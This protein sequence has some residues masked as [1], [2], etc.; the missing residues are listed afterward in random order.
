MDFRTELKKRI[1]VCDGAMGTRLYTKG[2]FINR[3]FEE[4]SLS[5]PYLVSEIHREYIEAGA[6]ILESNTFGANRFKLKPYGLVDKLSDIVETGV[7]LAKNEAKSNC[8]VA[9]S[10][11]PLGIPIKLD[12]INKNEVHKAFAEI[13]GILAKSGADLLLLETF[14]DIVELEMAVNAVRSVCDLPVI[15][16]AAV[17]KEER[18]KSDF[19]DRMA[20]LAARTNPDVIGLNCGAGPHGILEGIKYLS[21]KVSIPLSA[22]PNAGEPQTIDGRTLYL[23]TPEYMAEFTRRLVQSGVQIV[24]GCCGTGP[25]HIKAI[26]EAVKSLQPIETKSLKPIVKAGASKKRN[27][28]SIP[29][30]KKS[31]FGAK[32][33]KQFVTCVELDPPHGLDPS[34]V[35]ENAVN[36]TKAGIDAVNISDGPRA[37]ARMNPITLAIFIKRKTTIEPIVHVCCRDRNIIGLQSDLIGMHALGL[38]NILAITGDPPKLGNYDYA[39]GV[40]DVDSIGLVQMIQMLNSGLDLAGNSL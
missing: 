24:G 40:F 28:I 7:R 31:A 20:A 19:L 18:I 2:V 11:G 8:F 4:A 35:I 26:R 12:V 32:L 39:T 5:T 3:C 23:T 33:G 25:E 29:A 34:K 21:H 13:A 6:D 30:E 10:I 1:L 14:H 38:N 36:L 37:T 22:Q 27:L 17:P 16:Q 9:G 15:I